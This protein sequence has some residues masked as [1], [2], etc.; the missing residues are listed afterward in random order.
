MHEKGKADVDEVWGWPVRY[1]PEVQQPIPHSNLQFRPA[2][3]AIGVYPIWFVSFTWEYGKDQEPAVLV[4]DEKL[5]TDR[6]LLTY[7]GNNP[8]E[9]WLNG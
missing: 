1:E 5:V 7:A 6:P 4:E 9:H 3:F 2:V 8:S